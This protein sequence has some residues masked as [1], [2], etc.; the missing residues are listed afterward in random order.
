MACQLWSA[1]VS[2]LDL[3][4]YTEHTILADEKSFTHTKLNSLSSSQQQCMSNFSFIY[5]LM[6][7]QGED[8]ELIEL[9]PLCVTY[10]IV[11][12]YLAFSVGELKYLNYF[13]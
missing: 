13:I 9:L 2:C 10:F 1:P 7:S 12:L 4:N 3:E 5:V 8:R 6:F 11:F